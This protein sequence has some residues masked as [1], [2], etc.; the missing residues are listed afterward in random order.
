[1]IDLVVAARSANTI[2]NVVAGGALE[3]TLAALG[4]AAAKDALSKVSHAEDKRAQVW[5][6]VNH[7]EEAESVLRTTI[8]TRGYR[9]MW[10]DQP[11]LLLMI[12]KR[13]YILGLMAVCY[14]YL[15]EKTLA[16]RTLSTIPGADEGYEVRITDPNDW[17]D[18]LN[19]GVQVYSPLAWK[20]MLQEESP[21][22]MGLFK[23]DWTGRYWYHVP[24]FSRS[25]RATW[26]SGPRD[27]LTFPGLPD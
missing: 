26:S 7:L 23:G 5:S 24:S 19:T 16:E 3:S 17:R 13:R 1:M 9:L 2:A 20:G 14:R 12:Y 10:V 22:R 11:G 15:G 6:A 4:L 25:L 27:L 21:Y 8:Q 18:V